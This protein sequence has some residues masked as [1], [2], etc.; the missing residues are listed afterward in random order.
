MGLL[1]LEICGRLKINNQTYD[2]TG[3]FAE[4]GRL[5]RDT[6]IMQA[7]MVGEWDFILTEPKTIAQLSDNDIEMLGQKGQEQVSGSA[8]LAIA[9]KLATYEQLGIKRTLNKAR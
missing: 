9:L 6:V 2:L 3:T 5:A 7:A 1:E 8:F 4:V